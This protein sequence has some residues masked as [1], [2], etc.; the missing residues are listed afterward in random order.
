[1][2][3][4][5]TDLLEDPTYAFLFEKTAE[6]EELEEKLFDMSRYENTESQSLEESMEIL[7]YEG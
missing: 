3:A 6:E 5:L 2:T 4:T 1:M 7:G